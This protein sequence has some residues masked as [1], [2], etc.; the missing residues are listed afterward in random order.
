[1]WRNNPAQ[2]VRPAS[3]G[4]VCANETMRTSGVHDRRSFHEERGVRW[5]PHSLSTF[6]EM[7][8][9]KKG[10]APWFFFNTFAGLP[11]VWEQSEE[12]LVRLALFASVHGASFHARVDPQCKRR[13][14]QRFR[15]VPTEVELRQSPAVFLRRSR[16]TLRRFQGRQEARLTSPTATGFNPEGK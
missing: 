4:T 8:L 1:M 13:R 14:W 5:P 12:Q 3:S 7:A 16:I 2:V 10:K 9:K 11:A 15:V 6:S